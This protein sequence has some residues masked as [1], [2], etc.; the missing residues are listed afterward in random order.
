M[1]TI[2][3]LLSL[4]V[5]QKLAEINREPDCPFTMPMRIPFPPDWPSVVRRRLS[6]IP[7]GHT[8]FSQVQWTSIHEHSRRVMR[9]NPLCGRAFSLSI[10]R[11]ARE[12]LAHNG[13][14]AG[15]KSCRAHHRLTAGSR[16]PTSSRCANCAGP[17]TSRCGRPRRG[18]PR[19]PERPPH[20]GDAGAGRP[21]AAE[22]ARPQGR[23]PRRRGPRPCRGAAP[24]RHAPRARRAPDAHH[25]PARLRPIPACS[26]AK[27]PGSTGSTTPTSTPAP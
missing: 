21:D 15:S 25:P 9:K 27:W 1:S 17:S 10:N 11:L 5:G 14:V 19:A 13:L 18:L 26:P 3:R 8:D 20:R 7:L 6:R 22:R 16:L 23:G 4:W 24:L 12:S 2:E